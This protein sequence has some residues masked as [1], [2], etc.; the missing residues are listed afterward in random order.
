MHV[1]LRQVG[2]NF[3]TSLMGLLAWASVAVDNSDALPCTWPTTFW[4]SDMA[5]LAYV[6]QLAA[7]PQHTTCSV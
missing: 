5:V 7:R 1:G 2:R 3:T 4:Q 6:G